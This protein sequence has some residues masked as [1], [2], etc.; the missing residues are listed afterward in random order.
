MEMT[1]MPVPSLLLHGP[2]SYAGTRGR[3]LPFLGS[4]SLPRRASS[5]STD[6]LQMPPLPHF[7]SGS[8]QPEQY[9]LLPVFSSRTKFSLCLLMA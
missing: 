7:P 4:I 5:P 6:P 8:P 2:C 9:L 3:T 1:L